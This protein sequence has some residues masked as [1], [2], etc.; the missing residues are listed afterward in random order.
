MSAVNY[1]VY[2]NVRTNLAQASG[3]LDRLAFYGHAPPDA[4][5][6]NESY[7]E[8][9]WYKQHAW[10][11]NAKLWR[12]GYVQVEVCDFTPYPLPGASYQFKWN[13]FEGMK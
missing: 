5:N 1:D 11:I 6:V 8:F 3:V 4:V 9:V 13:I 7:A 12:G 2:E 10:Y